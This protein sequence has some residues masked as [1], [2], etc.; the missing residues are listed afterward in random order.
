MKIQSVVYYVRLL[1][2]RQTPGETS[3]NLL[4]G[5]NKEQLCYFKMVN[6]FPSSPSVIF[7]DMCM[8]CYKE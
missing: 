4:G 7:A 2:D 5:G 1:T 3:L 6:C 8:S